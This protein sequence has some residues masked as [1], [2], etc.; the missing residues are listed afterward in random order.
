MANLPHDGSAPGE[1]SRA[2]DADIEEA[3]AAEPELTAE[4]YAPNGIFIEITWSRPAGAG[5]PDNVGDLDLHF[6]AP[7]T[8]E[9][10][11][12]QWFSP[13]FDC[14]FRNPTPDWGVIGNPEDNPNLLLDSRG[15]F[16]AYEV[17]ALAEPQATEEPDTLYTVGVH[18]WSAGMDGADPAVEVT[19][20]VHLASA[21]VFEGTQ[22]MNAASMMW[23][24][25]RISWNDE[26]AQVIPL[27]VPLVEIGP[28]TGID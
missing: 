25:V 22:V 14:H 13:L 26:D 2:P 4:F 27:D 15:E 3:D 7:M 9:Q 10:S 8:Y 24:A 16:E 6:L 21:L 28:G 5:G 19:M 20:R 17:L 23:P 12:S 1:Q 11:L 18:Y